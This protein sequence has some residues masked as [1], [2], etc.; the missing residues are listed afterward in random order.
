MADSLGNVVGALRAGVDIREGLPTPD[1]VTLMGWLPDSLAAAPGSVRIL[2]P[3]ESAGLRL[4]RPDASAQVQRRDT[5]G[6][7]TEDLQPVDGTLFRLLDGWTEDEPFRISV[8]LPDADSVQTLTFRRA[9]DREVGALGVVVESH[10]QPVRGELMSTGRPR[11]P[12]QVRSMSGSTLLFDGLPRG[13]RGRAR[14]FVDRDGD[15]VWNPGSLLPFE[16]AEPVDW[17]TFRESVRAR[18]ETI[19][20]DTLRFLPPQTDPEDG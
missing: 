16:P 13:W 14:V 4:S 3:I 5:T 1:A 12:V 19:A 17:V 2:W 15:G 18:W 9:T 8:A 10:G 6:A 11:P 7:R 20:A